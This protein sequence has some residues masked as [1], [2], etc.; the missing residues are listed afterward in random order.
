MEMFLMVFALALL[1]VAVSAGMFAAATRGA[2]SVPGPTRPRAAAAVAAPRFF[3]E[4][5]VAP[6]V[7][8]EVL[9][10][11]LEQHIRLEQAAAE[12]FLI[13]PTRQSLHSRTTSPLVH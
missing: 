2:D 11:Q 8:I 1:G 10:A 5:P 12:A 6:A 9:L 7:P 4:R 3:V 13:A